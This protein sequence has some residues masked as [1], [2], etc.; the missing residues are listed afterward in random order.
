M[1]AKV[2]IKNLWK[3]TLLCDGDYVL[4][5]RILNL[6]ITHRELTTANNWR[7]YFKISTLSQITN[8]SG[9][10]ILPAY[11]ERTQV[12]NHFPRERTKWPRQKRPDLDTFRIW[13]KVLIAATNCSP[14]GSMTQ[15]GDWHYNY[16]E[17]Y[18]ATTVLHK[19]KEKMAKW[20]PVSNHWQVYEHREINYSFIKFQKTEFEFEDMIDTSQYIPVDVTE[21]NR[22]YSIASRFLSGITSPPR[23]RVNPTIYSFHEYL[24]LDNTW[25]QQLFAKVRWYNY[26]HTGIIQPNDI[27][28]VCSDGGVRNGTAGFGIVLSINNNS[29]MSTMMQLREEYGEFTSYRSEAYGMLGALTLYHKMQEYTAIKVGNRQPITVTIYSDSESLVDVVNNQ[30]WKKFTR[31]FHYSADA[32]VIK[33]IVLLIRSI[34]SH[35]EIVLIRHVKGHQDRFA[36]TN[37]SYAATLNIE[38]DSL[39]TT[40]LDLPTQSHWIDTKSTIA[41]ITIKDKFI[42]SHHTKHLSEA[43]LIIPYKVHMNTINNWSEDIFETIWWDPHGS[44]MSKFGTHQQLMIQKYLN[45]R[46]PTNRRENRYYT[47]IPARCKLCPETETQEHILLCD[48]CEHRIIAR[49]QYLVTLNSYLEQSHLTQDTVRIISSCVTAYLNKAAIPTTQMLQIQDNTVLHLAYIDQSKI[50]W[51]QWLKGKMAKAW[52]AV[53]LHD[54]RLHVDQPGTPHRVPTAPIWATKIIIMT[55]E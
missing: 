15:L 5:D 26:Q 32:D 52:K 6:Q 3:T 49:R 11:F 18:K 9:N 24:L 4:M 45:N 46:L 53:Y 38:A 43:Y 34:R 17:T 8:Y 40:S 30:C 44:A 41:R 25:D 55:W 39:A 16:A 42:S 33:E 2:C 28:Q 47:Y 35:Q 1:Q 29:I 21:D 48:V 54:I 19:N 23:I 12:H 27:L 13:K 50:G 31:R 14:T 51:D 10:K 36:N 20:C 37:L 7:L 22:F